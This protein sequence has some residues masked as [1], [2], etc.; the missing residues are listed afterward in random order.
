MKEKDTIEVLLTVLRNS[1]KLMALEAETILAS[2]VIIELSKE[3]NSLNARVADLEKQI[4]KLQE[5]ANIRS[6]PEP[7]H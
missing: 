6:T 4:V 7:V 5:Q 3:N 2:N 1:T